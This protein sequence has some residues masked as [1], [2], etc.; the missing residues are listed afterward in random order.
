MKAKSDKVLQSI[1]RMEPVEGNRDA[2][3]IQ[4]RL[5]DGRE[6]FNRLVGDVCSAVM[7]ISALDLAMKSS[8]DKMSHIS[9]NVKRISETV[10]SASHLTEENMDEVVNAHEGFAE[11]ITQ[12]SA[13]A[14]EIMEDM[15][16]SSREISSIVE[17]SQTTIDKS[18][19][20]KDDM[21][22]LLDII[23]GMNEVIKG[24]NSISAQT[25]MLALNASIEA[26]R[27]GEAGKGFAVV[28]EQIRSLADETKQLTSNM[29]GFI[30]EIESAA[31]MSSDS[32]DQSVVELDAMRVNLA[33]VLENNQSN[34]TNIVNITDSITTIA[35]TSEEIFSAVTNVQ[36]Q[37]VKLREECSSL[38]AQSTLLESV[39]EDL[40]ENMRPV[41]QIEKGLDDSAKLM[42]QM[43]QDVFYMLNNRQFI[44]NVQNAITAHQNWLNTL[45]KIVK[46]RE[47][48]PLQTDDT[49]CAFGHFYYAMNPRNGMISPLW[50]GLAEKHRRFHGYGKNVIAAIKSQ[51]YMKA[52]NEYKQ[53]V[54]LS[55]EL[56]G[57]F[58]RIIANAEALEKENLQV[59]AE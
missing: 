9:D 48:L 14:G 19:K 4:S 31:T 6:K 11:S 10:V 22:Q 57:D 41:A 21:H 39:S 36:D 25:N 17:E 55:E 7:K 5:I 30:S 3:E 45:H 1:S 58:R 40:T 34:V 2:A 59:F 26:A 43:V 56:I 46:S 42:G 50:S 32:L 24:I 53:A 23:K 15:E 38:N 13:A 20:M 33:K 44:N 8:T 51:D 35:A 27:A 37:M 54:K 47:C 18:S 16:A 49:K 12:V 52:E 28:A 29:D